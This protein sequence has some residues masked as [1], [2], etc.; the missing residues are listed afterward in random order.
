MRR[1]F[2][3][4]LFYVAIKKNKLFTHEIAMIWQAPTE[5]EKNVSIMAIPR[6]RAEVQ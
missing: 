2:Q 4:W 1:T 3:S 6:V 5:N